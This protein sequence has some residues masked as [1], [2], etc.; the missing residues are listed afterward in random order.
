M[1]RRLPRV[2]I[3]HNYYKQP[4]GEDVVVSAEQSLL[5]ANGHDVRLA[6]VDNHAIQASP[7]RT[8]KAA[9]ETAYA[10]WGGKWLAR[11]LRDFRPDVVHVHNFFPRLTPAVY[12]ACTAAGVPVIQTLHNFRLTCA[13]PYLYRNGSIC[14]DCI[15]GSPYR[16]AL[17]GCYRGSRL[18]S[19]AVA[20]MIDVHRRQDTWNSKVTRFI[21]LTEFAKG[22]FVAAGVRPEHIVVKPNFVT[23]RGTPDSGHEH[24][25]VRCGALY[26]GRL[27]AEK[28]IA[29]LLEAW[30]A[31]KVPLVIAGDG[32]LRVM[33]D[34]FSHNSIRNAGQL[35]AEEVAAS[36]RSAAFLV[37]PSEWYETFGLVI[38]EAFCQGLPVIASRLGAMAE[39][40]EDGMTGLLFTAGDA[41]DLA[42]KV[43]WASTHPLEMRVMGRN[44]RLVYTQRYTPDE[45]Y[46][47]LREI[48]QGVVGPA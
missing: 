12:D 3:V 8:V 37:M 40:V 13:S 17:H 46:R 48:Y 39:L 47:K 11:Y 29:T 36:M 24:E 44:A 7:W 16:A 26:V 34:R 20:R 28:G 43:C 14:E 31:L 42:A 21:A 15:G 23:D 30:R 25:E 41:A 10:P 38:V 9:L 6:T 2:L 18:G 5:V 4:G 33:V 45:N 22:K 32:P 35:S 1:N 19:L 27:S